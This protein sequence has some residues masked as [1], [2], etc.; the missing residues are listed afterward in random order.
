MIQLTA[1]GGG[2]LLLFGALFMFLPSV[3]RAQSVPA[4]V[5]LNCLAKREGLFSVSDVWLLGG[6]LAGAVV[7]RPLELTLSTPITLFLVPTFLVAVRGRDFRRT[8]AVAA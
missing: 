3:S 2:L 7:A 5:T 6:F 1:Q 8:P 4:T